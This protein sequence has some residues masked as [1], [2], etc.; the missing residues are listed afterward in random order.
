[1]DKRRIVHAL[2]VLVLTLA[3]GWIRGAPGTQAAALVQIG[4]FNSVY[5]RYD[6]DEWEKRNEF[7]DQP[8]NSKGEPVEAL[9]HRD[10]PG[11]ILHDNLGRGVPP[12]WELQVTSQVVGS[13]EYHVE[14]WTDTEA[15]EPVLRVYQYP[16]GEPGDGT[17]IELVIDRQHEECIRSAEAVLAASSGLISEP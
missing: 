5:L 9:Q 3:C 14:A 10:I 17:R 11:C 16:A 12:S 4:Y 2:I 8:Q 1:M 15:Q 6:P 7:P 13:L